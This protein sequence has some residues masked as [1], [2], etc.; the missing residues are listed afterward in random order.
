ME[1]NMYNKLLLLYST[2]HLN[3]TDKVK[4]YYALKGRDGKSGIVKQLN[5][6]QLAKSVLLVDHHHQEDITSFFN[7]WECPTELN[8]IMIKK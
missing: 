7:H 1:E 2:S 8:H 6:R 5:I 3:S 4:F